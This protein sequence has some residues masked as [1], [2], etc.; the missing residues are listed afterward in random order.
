MILVVLK[1]ND[2]PKGLFTQT[3]YTQYSGKIWW[4]STE[5]VQVNQ[6]DYLSGKITVS[7]YNN[8]RQ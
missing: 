7:N 5:L 2:K 6:E 8:F 4:N 3:E 1:V